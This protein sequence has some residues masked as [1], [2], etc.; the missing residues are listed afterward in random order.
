[1]YLM[2]ISCNYF[3]CSDDFPLG[4]YAEAKVYAKQTH[5][6]YDAVSFQ[7]SKTNYAD[8]LN[9]IREMASKVRM[10]ILCNVDLY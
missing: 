2:H 3:F 9:R 6:I 1:M 8:M 5:Q 7:E 10:Y 4:Y